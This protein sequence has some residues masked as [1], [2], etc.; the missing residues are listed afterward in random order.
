MKKTVVLVLAIAMVFSLNLAVSAEND[1]K[2][3]VEYVPNQVIDIP[4]DEDYFLRIQDVELTEQQ[5]DDLEQK[6]A[7]VGGTDYDVIEADIYHNQTKVESNDEYFEIVDGIDITFYR[8]DAAK[9][10]AVFYYRDGKWIQLEHTVE[11][12]AIH[13]HFPHL[14]PVA[15]AFKDSSG[16]IPGGDS[17]R[18]GYPSAVWFGAASAVLVCGAVLCFV[19]AKKSSAK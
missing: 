11:G 14:C 16:N 7:E 2:A 10:I 17:P 13:C 6:V 8:D 12:T 15:F 4:V 18:T 1:G 19:K 5:E 9:V 3:S